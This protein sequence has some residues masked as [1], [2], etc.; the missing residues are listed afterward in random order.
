MTPQA[1]IEIVRNAGGELA[2]CG[3]RISHRLPQDHP[4]K[5]LILDGDHPSSIYPFSRLRAVLLRNRA[6]VLGTSSVE[7]LHHAHGARKDHPSN[8]AGV[9]A[10]RRRRKRKMS[11]HRVRRPH[12]GHFG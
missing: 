10:L 8:R 9:L 12:K 11:L 6:W 3:D 7:G 2:V 4:A 1:V 5:G